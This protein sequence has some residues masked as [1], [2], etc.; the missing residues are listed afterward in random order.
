MQSWISINFCQMWRVLGVGLLWSL[1]PLQ[2]ATAQSFGDVPSDQRANVL[3]AVSNL[4]QPVSATNWKAG[5][6]G[7]GAADK[8]AASSAAIK[9]FGSELFSGGFRGTRADGLNPD[10][11]IL[12][13]DQ[14]TLR[15]WGAVE[16]D[17]VLPVDAQGN[18]FIPTIGPVAVMG[19]SHQQLEQLVRTAVT[20]VYPGSV[21][22]Y[23]NLQGVQPVAVYVAGFVA[24]PG[25]YAGIPSDSILYFL[26]QAGGV[27]EQL[28]SYRQVRLLRR[29]QQIAVM[30]LYD[31]ILSGRL[32]H[33]QLQDGDTIVVEKRGPVVTVSGNVGR[34]YQYELT[35]QALYGQTLI[36]LAQL[37]ASVSH[38]LLRGSRQAKPVAEYLSL[39]AF[40]TTQVGNGDDVQFM[41]DQRSNQLVI[42]LEGSYQ[43]R[44]HFVVPKNT[45]LRELLNN[46]P[47]DPQASDYRNVSLR[48]VSVA[49]QQRKSLEDSLRR[50]ETTYLGAPSSTA[51]ESAIRVREAE[52]ISAFVARVREI[53]PNGRM[54]LS[55]QGVLQD[56]RLQD[57][58]IITLP[59]RTDA[60]LV[61]GEV[62]I[63]QSSV[64]VAGKSVS[65]YI[66][67]A[68][69]FSQ[70][71][72]EDNIL[73][74]RP[75]GEVRKASDVTLQPGDEILVLPAVST[76]NL[77]L[78]SAITQIL[79]QVAVATK[80][81]V[82]L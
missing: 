11:K 82:D 7:K 60:V 46:V 34:S 50:L 41:A 2:T 18:I 12:P 76:K 79:Y 14:I 19:V 27:D 78:A 71:A 59:A 81:A 57:G 73:V 77:Q 65:D 29:Q 47:V 25:R 6:I 52:L 54:V 16:I 55:E 45:T 70:H 5:T 37:N 28:G 33:G 62:Y 36:E 56:I 35:P 48:R 39:A 72:D 3:R 67:A 58:D 32:A 9:P 42:Q 4:Q 31:F 61:S 64:F 26:D 30:D 51:E 17:R 43:G 40:A 15:V 21:Q 38:V 69:G 22:V 10:Y 68:G 20:K 66:D 13:G 44:S 53:R 74:V 49:E 23:T 8:P 75:N 63:P 1:L 24:K 80:V